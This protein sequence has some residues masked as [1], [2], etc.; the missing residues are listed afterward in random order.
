MK[1]C[2]STVTDAFCRG[3]T[4]KSP[5]F[6]AEFFVAVVAPVVRGVEQASAFLEFLRISIEAFQ[7]RSFGATSPGTIHLRGAKYFAARI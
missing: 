7:F 1:N 2:V 3:T 6:R 4:G 5:D